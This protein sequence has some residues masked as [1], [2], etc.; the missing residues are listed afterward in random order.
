MQSDAREIGGCEV[1]V[2]RIGEGPPLVVLHNEDGPRNASAFLERLG[3]RFAVHV[4]RLPGWSETRR[5]QHVRSVRDVALVAQE[6]LEDFDEPVPLVGLSFG[7]WVAAEIAA[8]APGLVAKLALVSP[9]GVKIGGREDRDFA[10]IYLLPEPERTGTYYAAGGAPTLRPGAN[11]DLYLEKAIADEAVAR[12]CWQ[13]FMH[14][15]TLPGRLRRVR[16]PTL[17]VSGDRDRFVL[18]PGY[19]AG[20]ASLIAGASHEAIAGAGH[21]PEEEAAEATA[22]RIV[23]FLAAEGLRPG[24]RSL[25][26]A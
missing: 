8:N 1:V 18:N 10:D 22:D 7:G 26:K 11:A 13:P 2:E 9:I 17:I 20:Y 21:R 16:A 5:G 4:P 6:Y 14:D 23:E 15:P 19:Y 12:F 25:A 3:E 24:R